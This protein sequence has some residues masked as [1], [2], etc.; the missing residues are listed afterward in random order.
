MTSL[1]E[2]SQIITWVQKAMNFG[3]RQD[4]ACTVINFNAR[5]LQRWQ[6]NQSLGDQRSCGHKHRQTSSVCEGVNTY[7]RLSI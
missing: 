4:R 5:T 3:A 6:V 1:A 2:R 7:W